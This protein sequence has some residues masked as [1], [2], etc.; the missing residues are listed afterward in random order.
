MDPTNMTHST[1]VLCEPGYYC[2]GGIKEPCPKGTFSWEFG[3]S[4][5]ESCTKCKVRG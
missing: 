1:Q 2:I 4:S 3:G 5:L